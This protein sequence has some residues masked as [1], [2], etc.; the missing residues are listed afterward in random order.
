MGPGPGSLFSPMASNVEV[1]E[2]IEQESKIFGGLKVKLIQV[3][4]FS[5]ELYL[6]C[7]QR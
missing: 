1:D 5:F 4:W 7:Q 6:S 3:Y 2:K